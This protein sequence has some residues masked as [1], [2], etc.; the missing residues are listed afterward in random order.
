MRMLILICRKFI[1]NQEN[2]ILKQSIKNLINNSEEIS[3]YH[4]EIFSTIFDT[5]NKNEKIIT[6]SLNI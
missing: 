6:I 1:L 5:E 3:M 4:S 2:E